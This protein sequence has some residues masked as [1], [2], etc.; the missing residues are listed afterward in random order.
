[1]WQSL[2]RKGKGKKKR[3]EGFPF[4]SFPKSLIG[5][6]NAFKTL[7][8]PGLKI[9]GVTR[10]WESKCFETR[11]PLIETFRGDDTEA[12]SSGLFF[13]FFLCLFVFSSFPG[14][15]RGLAPSLSVP[16]CL[17]FRRESSPSV[18]PEIFNRESMLFQYRGPRLKNCRGDEEVGIHIFT[19]ENVLL[20]SVV[21]AFLSFIF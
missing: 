2:L 14:V 4:S 16:S 3:V 5:N 11:G 17:K 7:M 19:E 13:V 15:M 9:A 10:R 8:D 18:I 20:S 21:F 6:P 12:F 1:M